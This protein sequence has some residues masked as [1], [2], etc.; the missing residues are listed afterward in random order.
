MWLWWLLW[1][2]LFRGDL[3]CSQ[4]AGGDWLGIRDTRRLFREGLSD[5]MPLLPSEPYDGLGVWWLF[6]CELFP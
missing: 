1:W 5:F 3:R 6:E 2:L 4:M